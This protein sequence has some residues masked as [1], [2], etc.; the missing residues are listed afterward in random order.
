MPRRKA[1]S[2]E[3]ATTGPLEAV[4]RRAPAPPH[5]SMSRLSVG[6]SSSRQVVALELEDEHLQARLLAAAEHVIRPPGGVGE[7]VAGERLHRRL[8]AAAL[9][10]HDVHH[11]A[12]GEVAR[13]CS[14]VK[15]PVDTRGADPRLAAVGSRTP[16]ST[17]ISALLPEPLGPITPTRSPKWISSENA[18]TQ[19]ADAERAQIEHLASRVAAP[20]PHRD[21]GVAG[22]RRRR[23]GGAKRFQRDSIA[24]ARL[25]QSGA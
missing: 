2:W 11:D 17:R 18:E 25:A 20:D 4:E 23:A 9:I 5:E 10:E 1:R 22:R 6:S 13:D 14:W 16:A 8:H 15:K 3:T 7:P 24:S 12:A 21:P 19:P